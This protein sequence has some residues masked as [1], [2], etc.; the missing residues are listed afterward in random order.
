MKKHFSVILILAVKNVPETSNCIKI[1][2]YVQTK[3]KHENKKKPAQVKN[4]SFVDSFAK[5]GLSTSVR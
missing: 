5:K 2:S 3:K 1:H 4:C